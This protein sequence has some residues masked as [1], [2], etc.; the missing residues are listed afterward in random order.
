LRP[1][2]IIFATGKP[3]F[4]NQYFYYMKKTILFLLTILMLFSCSENK[5]YVIAVSQCSE[6]VW[7]EKLNGELMAG[8]YFYSNMELRIVSANDDDRTQ[9]EQI[10][11]FVDEGVDLLIVSPNQMNTVTPAI[12]RAYDKGIPVIIFDRKT[13]SDKYTAFIGADNYEVGKAIGK[14]VAAQSGGTPLN[15]AEIQGLRGSSPTIERH[16]GFADAIKH[17]PNIHI[18]ASRY[19]GWRQDEARVQM[20]SILAERTDIGCVFGHNDRMAEGARE[21]VERRGLD[22]GRILFTGIDALASP[23]GGMEAVRDGRIAASYFYPTRGDLVLQ[24]AMNILEGR[25]YKRD[26]YLK[27]ALVTKDN[28]EQMLMQDEEMQVQIGRIE[29]ANKKV[30]SYLTQYNHQKIYLVLVVTILL[31]CLVLFGYIYRTVVQKRR[32]AEEAADAKLQFFTNI[33]HEFRTPLTLIADPVDRLLDDDTLTAGQR[34]LLSMVRRNVK[35]VLRLVREILDFRK[36]Q[37]GKMSMTLSTFSLDE[38]LREWTDAFIPA[39]ERRG[40]AL[41]LDVPGGTMITADNEKIESIVYNLLSNAIKYTPRGGVVSVSAARHGGDVVLKVADTGAGIPKDSLPQVFD[42]FFQAGTCSA[43]GTGIG[44]AIVRAFA[45]LHGGTVSVESEEG[46][47]AEFTV[48]IPSGAGRGAADAS[49]AVSA[50]DDGYAVRGM[51]VEKSAPGGAGKLLDMVEDGRGERLRVL[52]VDDNDDVRGYIS[53]VLSGFYDVC[54]APDGQSGLDT[55][56]GTVPD[57]IICDIMMPVMDGLEMCRRIKSETA[58]SH[59]PVLLLTARTQEGQRAEGYDCGAD[60]YIT[61]PFSSKVL[62]SRVRNLLDNRRRLRE[63]YSKDGL[64]EERPESADSIF[65]KSLRDK[66]AANMADSGFSVETLSADM[67][68]S[69]VQLYRKVK[70]LTGSTPVEFIRLVRL[71]RAERLLRQG[72]KTVAEVSYEVGFSSPSYFSKCFKEHFGRLPGEV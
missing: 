59:I 17:F 58:T 37:K 2:S 45:E 23:G 71:R 57:L 65:I 25:P 67:G 52:V 69:R 55:A 38:S 26:N 10:N 8:K 20:D 18:V 14:Y 13:G 44:L 72:G 49:A 35:V 66:I 28:V 54:E 16:R 60:G 11:R 15:V 42:R 9:T 53:S 6:D 29:E 12:D 19:A 22:A 24:L 34:T 33:S 63:A 50:P 30:D 36:T 5:K 70:A 43:G 51:T 46:R 41:R 56:A 47:G 64:A 48:V 21:T 32:M 62:L 31:L 27:A 39:A 68:L 40:V 61:K 1:I 7:R 3:E 4:E